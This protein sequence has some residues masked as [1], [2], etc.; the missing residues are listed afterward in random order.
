MLT[1]TM[2][3]LVLMIASG[4]F[5][6]TEASGI[7]AAAARFLFFAFFYLVVITA[8][9][10]GLGGNPPLERLRVW[11]RVRP[12]TGEMRQAKEPKVVA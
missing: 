9:F 10:S 12:E 4:L 3:F 8:F 1:W 2:T 11:M 5:G 7:E 6:W